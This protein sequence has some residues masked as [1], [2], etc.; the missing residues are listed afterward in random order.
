[1]DDE[2]DDAPRYGTHP[3]VVAGVV[4]IASIMLFSVFFAIA[5]IL[6]AVFAPPDTRDDAL[7]ADYLTTGRLLI[8]AFLAVSLTS[9]FWWYQPD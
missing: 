9:L 8:A 5:L 6:I 4:A 1:M 2:F 7:L 3:K